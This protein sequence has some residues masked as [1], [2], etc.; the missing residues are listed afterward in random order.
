MRFY[1]HVHRY[2]AQDSFFANLWLPW[3][4]LYYADGR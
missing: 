4:I 1:Q 3:Y 2:N